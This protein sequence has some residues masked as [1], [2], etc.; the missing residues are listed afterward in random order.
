MAVSV[1]CLL[2]AVCIIA[3]IDVSCSVPK[4]KEV[5]IHTFID[6][7]YLNEYCSHLKCCKC[8]IFI[9]CV[10]VFS[11]HYLHP[12]SDRPAVIMMRDRNEYVAIVEISV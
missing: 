5:N 4:K 11:C 9:Y 2:S 7:V 8:F 3:L 6:I 1:N 12:Q 10:I